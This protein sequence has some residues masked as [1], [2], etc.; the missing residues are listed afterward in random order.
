MDVRDLSLHEAGDEHL[1]RVA[2]GAREIE[3]LASLRMS[4]PVS[5][6]WLTGETRDRSTSGSEH[7]AMFADERQCRA[8]GHAMAP[9]VDDGV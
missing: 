6:T 9:F 5:G 7:H 8:A 1:G 4:P 2:H 3:D